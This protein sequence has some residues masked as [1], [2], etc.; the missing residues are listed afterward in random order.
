[1]VISRP[2]EKN[3]SVK[4]CCQRPAKIMP[5]SPTPALA[6]IRRM[7]RTLILLILTVLRLYIAFRCVVVLIALAEVPIMHRVA[8]IT[9]FDVVNINRK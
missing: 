3:S 7:L 1:M 2:I 5:A 6:A 9:M 8:A 4:W